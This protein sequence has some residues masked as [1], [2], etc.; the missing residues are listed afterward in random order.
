MLSRLNKHTSINEINTVIV[1]IT[2]MLQY[3]KEH[4]MVIIWVNVTTYIIVNLVYIGMEIGMD[5]LE[6]ITIS[7][8]DFKYRAKS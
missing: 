4:H 2:L 8:Y 3:I 1:Y 6:W 7:K 5:I